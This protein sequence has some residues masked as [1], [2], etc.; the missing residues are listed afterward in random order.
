M[1]LF[2][3]L[4]FLLMSLSLSQIWSFSKIM[5]PVRNF[6]AKIPYIRT[7]LI[8]PECSSFWVGIFTS[9][10]YNPLF[11]Y[12]DSLNIVSTVL[13]GS[14]THLFAVYLYKIHNKL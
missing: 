10:F 5:S 4:L 14:I 7:P 12:F 6:I 3:I 8:C 2:D 1:K 9:F 11:N 13:C